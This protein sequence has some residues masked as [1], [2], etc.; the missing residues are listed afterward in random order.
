[1]NRIKTLLLMGFMLMALGLQAQ[2]AQSLIKTKTTHIVAKMDLYWAGVV[3]A[4]NFPSFFPLELEINFPKPRLSAVAIVSPWYRP[5]NT[6]TK[7]Y[8][9]TSFSGGVGLRY[10]PFKN[11]FPESATGFFVEPEL[12][13]RFT[14][15]RVDSIGEELERTSTLSL[16]PFIGIG[17]QHEFIDL[18]YLQAR[19]S[20]GTGRDDALTSYQIGNNLTILPWVGFG[21]AIH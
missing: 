4:E 5:Y 13:T 21:I 18:L 17:Y 20:I 8:F 12:L 11:A 1:M 10:Y 7:Q 3:I 14:S 15:T 19:V 2:D 16:G 9:E 6:Q